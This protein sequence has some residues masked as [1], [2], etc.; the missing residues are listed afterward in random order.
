MSLDIF[1]R[2]NVENTQK[3]FSAGVTLTQI[4]NAFLR[5]DDG[6]TATDS[7]DMGSHK[8]VNAAYDDGRV[9]HEQ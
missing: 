7:I 2:T 5:R 8:I 9:K 1:G 4:D 3:L 6:N